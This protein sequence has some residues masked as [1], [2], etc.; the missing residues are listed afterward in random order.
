MP[1]GIGKSPQFHLVLGNAPAQHFVPRFA[2]QCLLQRLQRVQT[3]FGRVR[4]TIDKQGIARPDGRI[5]GDIAKVAAQVGR[6]LLAIALFFSQVG[7]PEQKCLHGPF[8]LPVMKTINPYGQNHDGSEKPN[9]S[10]FLQSA[11]GW[12]RYDLETRKCRQGFSFVRGVSDV[13]TNS[14]ILGMLGGI[15][16]LR[17]VHGA[18]AE[19]DMLAGNQ[20]ISWFSSGLGE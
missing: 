15:D 11:L 12:R 2:L 16:Q 1:C 8:D 18:K 17:H 7:L 13:L 19:R 3:G 20:H 5:C 4:Q 14:R 6:R 9:K 10:P